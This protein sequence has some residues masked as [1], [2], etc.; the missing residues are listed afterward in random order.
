MFLFT[1]IFLKASAADVEI[2]VNREYT[3]REEGGVSAKETRRV[4]NTTSDKI[5]RG[6]DNE[7]VFTITA[8][9]EDDNNKEILEKFVSTATIKG[10]SGQTLSFSTEYKASSVLLRVP[11][12]QSIGSN[13]S[14]TFT[15]EYINEQLAQVS[16]ALTDIY[17]Q[18]FPED[19]SFSS[20]NVDYEYSFTLKV[21]SSLGEENFATPDPAGRS[22]E[23]GYDVY[24]YSQTQLLGTYVWVQRGKSQ[25]YKFQIKQKVPATENFN[26]G[27]KNEFSMVIPRSLNGLKIDQIA[28]F[29]KITPEPDYI[30][31]DDDNNIIGVFKIQSDLEEEIVIE[32]Y[33]VV[34]TKS[35]YDIE[36]AGSINDFRSELGEQYFAG[37]EFWEVSASDIQAKAS[38]LKGSETDVY[39]IMTNTYDFIVDSIDYSH[40]KRFGINERQG[41]LKTL[42]GGAAVCMEYSDLYITLLRA[43]G[44]AARAAFGYGYDSREPAD[45]QELHQWVQVYI[46]TIDKWLDADPT[47][48]ENGPA[49]I[50]GDMNHFLTHVASIDPNT[51]STLS[52]RTYGSKVVFDPVQFSIEVLPALPDDELLS[53]DD[54]LE[55][56][57][58]GDTNQLFSTLND[59]RSKFAAG[60]DSFRNDGVNLTNSAQLLVIASVSAAF[61]FAL[62]LFSF[63][64]KRFSKLKKSTSSREP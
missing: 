45:Q 17:I 23:G 63:I 19:F 12:P 6:F 62:F 52:G 58:Q 29:T 57:E 9:Y 34:N 38:N 49:L 43:Q 22:T 60:I 41:A 21:P 1:G 32:G 4:I 35:D 20:G 59:L 53:V 10:Q 30:A 7:E 27:N 14:Y 55:K 5:I 47:W 37:S 56:Y 8:L 13:S 46:P 15:L 39:K 33:A 54:L 24:D 11:Y 64:A 36:N 50:G 51:P 61:F 26:T 40:V 16:G 2:E 42:N 44:I 48:G 31:K 25:Y 28:Y 18:A 3:V